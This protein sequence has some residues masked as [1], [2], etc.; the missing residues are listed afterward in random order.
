MPLKQHVYSV[1][2]LS[3]SDRFDEQILQL[4]DR[5]V[6][7]PVCFEK[8]VN[9]AQRR[10]A[11]R[12]YD[13]VLINSP[14]PDDFGA[15]FAIDA[16]AKATTVALMFVKS[17]VYDGVYDKVSDYG[18]FTLKKPMSSQSVAQALD[19]LRATRERLRRMEK[20]SL[21]LQ[22]KMEEIKIV[23]HAKWVLIKALNMNEE[24]AHKYIEKQA[25][26]RCVTKREIAESII[27]T[28]K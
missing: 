15:R 17:E 1:L 27:S 8:S 11:E 6:F 25:M 9:G 14:L 7:Y 24:D 22:D 28:Y 21:S 19:F 18:V 4:L 20:K 26:D 16:S 10:T 5:S 13:I 23:N 3:S 2:I 12:S